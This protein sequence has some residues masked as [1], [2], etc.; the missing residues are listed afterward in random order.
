MKKAFSNKWVIWVCIA[1]MSSS[2]ASGD[3]VNGDFSITDISDPDFGWT[4]SG[5]AEITGGM[6]VFDELSAS[7]SEM[8]LFQPVELGQGNYILSYDISFSSSDKSESDIFKVLWGGTPLL[9]INNEGL[10]DYNALYG[11]TEGFGAPGEIW[12]YGTVEHSLAISSPSTNPL[13]FSLEVD[14]D[15]AY[16]LVNIDNVEIVPVP[17]AAILGS[18]GL[19]FSGWLLKRKR[20]V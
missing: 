15:S 20:M 16:T 7:S 4:L 9:S 3:L 6:A 14:N 17:P 18:L 1:V 2:T 5:G 8:T 19:T 11:L 13:M 10:K 12:W